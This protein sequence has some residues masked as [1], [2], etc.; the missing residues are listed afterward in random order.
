MGHIRT[1]RHRPAPGYKNM[2]LGDPRHNWQLDTPRSGIRGPAGRTTYSE[3]DISRVLYSARSSKPSTSQV[4]RRLSFAD[5]KA[6][7]QKTY[8]LDLAALKLSG[9]R[10]N[11]KLALPSKAVVVRLLRTP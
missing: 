2:A 1:A 5:L 3:K 9:S 4:D 10:L 6:S 7:A 8:A 11:S